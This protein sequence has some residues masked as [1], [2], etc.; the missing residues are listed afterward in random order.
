[1]IKNALKIALRHF[2]KNRLFTALNL[3]GLATGLACVLLIDWWVTDERRID[4]FN[5]KDARFYKV[6][7]TFPN[8]DGTT[9]MFDATQALLGRDLAANFPEVEY[10]VAV[11]PEGSGVISTAEEH[12]KVNCDMVDKDFFQVFSYRLIEGNP[13]NPFADPN[14]VLIS[15]S[16]ALKLFHRTTGIVGQSVDWN[17]GDKFDTTHIVVGVFAAPPPSATEQFDLLLSYELYL[18]QYARDVADWGSNGV[19]TYIT[20][21]EGTDAIA[22]GKKI[23]HYTKEKIGTVYSDPALLRGEGDVYIQRYSD[24]YLY[25]RFVNGVQSGGRIEYVRL[26]SLIALF[27]LVIACINF[28]NLSTAKAAGRMKEVGIKKTVGASRRSL[29]LYFMGESMLMAVL[30]LVMAVALAA[31]LLPYFRQITGKNLPL[32]VSTPLVVSMLAITVLTGLVSGSYPALYLSGFKPAWILGKGAGG[33]AGPSALR[34]GLVVFQFAI[35]VILITMVMVVYRQMNLI[36]TIHLGYNKEN[37]IR[38]TADGKLAM[39]E[40]GFL[41]ELREIPGVVRASDMGG[42]MTGRYSQA[43]TYVDWEGKPPGLEINYTGL[44]MDTGMMQL[45]GMQLVAGRAFSNQFG[46]DSASVIFNESAIAAMGLKDPIGK[47]VTVWRMQKRIIGIVKDFHFGSLYQKMG[48]FFFRYSRNNSNI[49]VRIQPGAEKQ[50]L[51]RI[52]ALYKQFNQWLPL[53]YRFLDDD[54]AQ[55]YAAEQRVSVLSRYFAGMTILISCLGLF[56]LA[57]FTAQKKEKEIA[58]RKV[59]GASTGRIIVLLTRE[60][61]ALVAV[62]LLIALPLAGWAASKWLETF[63]YRVQIGPVIFLLAGASILLITVVAVSY[64][65]IK[66]AVASP[67]KS[68]KRE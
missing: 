38:F 41:A 19:I 7:K 37:V 40:G 54:Y 10:A 59:V 18:Q 39:D 25:N 60:F 47:T 36:R 12:I 67:A 55:L 11:R 56:G 61:L 5:E 62:A 26:F 64:Q 52:S 45:L 6:L 13:K 53:E 20:L 68:L 28:M 58:I 23:R 66:A 32:Q 63:A 48:P 51:D 15:D 1:M 3:T 30:S 34:K 17:G 14:G 24:G 31:L 4:T 22:F 65:S 27:I 44:N 46:S 42:N 49:F 43:G 16:L 8:G 9:G 33:P 21:K 2:A 57:A 35:S 29:I 50:T